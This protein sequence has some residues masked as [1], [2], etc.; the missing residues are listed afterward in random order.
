[1]HEIGAR[2][3]DPLCAA[4]PRGRS[5]NPDLTPGDADPSITVSDLCPTASTSPPQ[6]CTGSREGRRVPRIR[7]RR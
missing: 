5:F 1:M 4:A 7:S 3:L 6:E 2:S